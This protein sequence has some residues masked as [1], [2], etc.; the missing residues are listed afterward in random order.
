MNDHTL[1]CAA[2]LGILSLHLQSSILPSS[3][4]PVKQKSYDITLNLTAQ[5][6]TKPNYCSSHDL[7]LKC[8]SKTLTFLDL[9]NGKMKE[10]SFSIF[11]FDARAVLEVFVTKTSAQV[12]A[13]PPRSHSIRTVHSSI[14]EL[15]TVVPHIR[16]QDKT[17]EDW[18]G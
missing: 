5:T 9:H 18:M 2:V 16:A 8:K 3:S 13:A 11:F 6:R 14:Y 4:R 10:L 17:S 1:E 7:F 12:P 15:R